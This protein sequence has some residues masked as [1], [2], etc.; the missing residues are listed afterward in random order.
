MQR[1]TTP[2]EEDIKGIKTRHHGPAAWVLS[3]PFSILSFT[4]YL[5]WRGD[6]LHSNVV[7]PRAQN[8]FLGMAK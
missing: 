8:S 3:P 1:I 5:A 2:E 4:P 7:A 6:H